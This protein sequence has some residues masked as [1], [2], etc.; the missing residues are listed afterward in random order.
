MKEYTGHSSQLFN[1]EE[2]RLVGGKGDGMRLLEVNNGQGLMFTVSLDRA[3][4]I[5]RIY[6]KGVNL[7]FFAP[8]GYVAPEYFDDIGLGF[9]KSFTAGFFTTCGFSAVGSP[10][11]DDGE[12]LPLHGTISHCPAE[13]FGYWNDGENLHI[14]LTVR[15]ARL[16]GKKYLL[17]R[18]YICPLDKNEITLHDTVENIDFEEAPYMVLY[19]MNM[20]Y[21]L[22]TEKS[23]ISL[24]QKGVVAR[25]E[26]A[27]KG[28]DKALTME[29]PV[30]GYAEQCFFYDMNKGFAKIFNPDLGFGLSI[31]YDTNE[32]P[33]F[34]EWKLMKSGEYVLGLEPGNCTPEG[35]DVL[36]AKGKLKF[37]KPGEKAEQ[38]IV[39]KIENN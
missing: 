21:P 11:T 15:D 13:Q 7:G 10:C 39:I 16:S 29:S 14:K 27:Q 20:G 37:L 28:I 6:Y 2:H 8:C 24:D 9:L 23:V 19:H 17:T 34:T 33:E 5:S 31:N 30:P 3:G 36:R 1:I 38:T 26:N 18:E 25:G 4:D 12:N 35:R 22:L 32:L